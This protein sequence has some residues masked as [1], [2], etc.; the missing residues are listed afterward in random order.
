LIEKQIDIK[1]VNKFGCNIYHETAK[2]NNIEIIRIIAKEFKKGKLFS[3]LIR[4]IFYI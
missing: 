3:Q 1:K 2:Y 4:I